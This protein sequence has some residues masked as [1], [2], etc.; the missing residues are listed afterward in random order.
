MIGDDFLG[1]I[2]ISGVRSCRHGGE[3]KVNNHKSNN[4]LRWLCTEW[5]RI[6]VLYVCHACVCLG[7]NNIYIY[8]GVGE[9]TEYRINR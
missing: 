6:G 8:M 3:I 9:H 1:S 4:E 2:R 5:K 7:C